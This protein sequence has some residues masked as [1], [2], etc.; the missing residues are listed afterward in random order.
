M[1]AE[2]ATIAA[3]SSV[4]SMSS[5]VPNFKKKS[6]TT[7]TKATVNNSVAIVIPDTGEF[8]EPTTPAIYPATAAKKKE[9]TPRKRAPANARISEP[10]AHQ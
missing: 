10:V 2:E 5:S 4:A 1:A 3:I 9:T 6:P 8:E 7:H